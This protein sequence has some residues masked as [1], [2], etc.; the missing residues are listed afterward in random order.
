MGGSAVRLDERRANDRHIHAWK[1]RRWRPKR[2]PLIKSRECETCEE[3]EIEILRRSA[4]AGRQHE[5]RTYYAAQF[6][7][8]HHLRKS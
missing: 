1:R 5:E 2:E 3:R 6:R 8:L 7:V 4:L